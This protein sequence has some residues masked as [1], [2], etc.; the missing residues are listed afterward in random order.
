M[1]CAPHAGLA[2]DASGGTSQQET[3]SPAATEHEIRSQHCRLGRIAEKPRAMIK[4]A[5]SEQMSTLAHPP[6]VTTHI[7]FGSDILMP[8]V[9]S[10]R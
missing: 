3:R 6:A 1:S 8:N 10:R 9:G 2:S 7:G 4:S 5:D